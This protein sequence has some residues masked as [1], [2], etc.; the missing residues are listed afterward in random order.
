[1]HT[2]DHEAL[3]ARL[4]RLSEGARVVFAAASATRMIPLYERFHKR[5]GHG[6]PQVLRDALES[7][8]SWVK[9][10]QKE[11]AAYAATIEVLTGLLPDDD[12][13]SVPPGSWAVDAISGAIYTVESLTDPDPQ[14]GTWA[15]EQV[16]DA[17]GDFVRSQW[18]ASR[19]RLPSPQE[20]FSDPVMQKLLGQYD[21]DLS[22]LEKLSP[23]GLSSEVER[24]RRRAEA[25]LPIPE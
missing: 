20:G 1:M 3:M 6:D 18:I 5:S 21:R 4:A 17:V 10:D 12:E 14:K 24:F 23:G 16:V 25:E 22:E 8:W 15:A 2:Y 11:P 9:G 7:A 19:G 13:G